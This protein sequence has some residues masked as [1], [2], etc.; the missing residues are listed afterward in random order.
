MDL[1]IYDLRIYYFLP[2]YGFTIYDVFACG[3]SRNRRFYLWIFG[4]YV[5]M[6]GA[7][8]GAKVAHFFLL[9]KFSCRKMQQSTE[10]L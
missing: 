1:P 2:I 6:D 5:Y 3:N 4:L 9:A 8:A 10:I 7:K